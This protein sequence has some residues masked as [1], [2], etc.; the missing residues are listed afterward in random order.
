MHLQLGYTKKYDI[1]KEHT[2]Q[3][4]VC[5]FHVLKITLRNDKLLLQMVV[6][7]NLGHLYNY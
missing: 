6:I 5:S 1:Q 3:E 7:L 2:A 4:G